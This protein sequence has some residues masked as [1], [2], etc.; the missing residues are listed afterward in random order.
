MILLSYNK[1]MPTSINTKNL[2]VITKNPE[3]LT[4]VIVDA[5]SQ[6]LKGVSVTISPSNVSLVTNNNGEVEFTLGAATKYD[7]LVSNGSNTVTVP[8]Y[9]TK[10]GSTRLVIN[11][12]YVK[13]VEK[14]LHPTSWFDSSITQSVLLTILVFMVLFIVW[15]LFRRSRIK[16]VYDNSD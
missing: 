9:V 5:K 6:P 10:N 8:Y 13:S 2:N 14:Q 1:N 4:V 16:K 11:P 15:K 12:V 3:V 7:I